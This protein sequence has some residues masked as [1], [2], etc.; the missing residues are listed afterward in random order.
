MWMLDDEEKQRFR[1]GK[2]EDRSF[3]V[4]TPWDLKKELIN[5]SKKSVA[6]YKPLRQEFATISTSG[7]T[8]L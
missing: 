4:V 2:N 1:G 3:W 7:N 5:F 8:P 6:T